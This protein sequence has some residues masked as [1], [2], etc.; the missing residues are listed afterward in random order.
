MPEYIQEWIDYDSAILELRT[1]TP[2]EI[3][4]EFNTLLDTINSSYEKIVD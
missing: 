4:K 1:N 2:L 3:Q